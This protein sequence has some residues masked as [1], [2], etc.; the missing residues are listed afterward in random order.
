M[1]RWLHL[2]ASHS[3]IVLPTFADEKQ[4]FC[5]QDAECCAR[6]FMAL[7]VKEVL[8]KNGAEPA[9]AFTP[10]FAGEVAAVA[11]IAATDPTGE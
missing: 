8:V 5:D 9:Y 4:H 2:A 6:R 3:D 11:G 10:D 1:H 7:G